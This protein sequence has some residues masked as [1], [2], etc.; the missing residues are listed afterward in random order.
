MGLTGGFADVGGLYDCLYGI[1]A[2]LA[3][4]RILD[5]YSEIRRQKY[6]EVIDPI[7]SGNLRRLW[8]PKAVENDEFIKM[9]RRAETDK[10]FAKQMQEVSIPAQPHMRRLIRFCRASSQSCMTLLN[11]TGARAFRS[12]GVQPEAHLRS[13]RPRPSPPGSLRT[14]RGR[15]FLTCQ[16]L[17]QTAA[18]WK[19]NI[20]PTCRSVTGRPG[21]STLDGEA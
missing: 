21:F 2:G 18:F 8:D 15:I 20:G 14:V 13:P 3:D 1:Y 6:Q 7:S 10:Q 16:S 4:E 12:L 9:I 11:I 19:T 5:K 17:P